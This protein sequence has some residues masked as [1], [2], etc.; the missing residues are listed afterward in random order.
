M[1]QQFVQNHLINRP[2]EE[3]EGKLVLFVDF[4]FK[5]SQLLISIYLQLFFFLQLMA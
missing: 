4:F 5:L 1:Q 3:F 2:V